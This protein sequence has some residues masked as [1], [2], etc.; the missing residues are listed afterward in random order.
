M[1]PMMLTT[2]AKE[3]VRTQQHP[4]GS[5]QWYQEGQEDQVCV[6]QG[7]GPQVLEKSK[8]CQEVQWQEA[9]S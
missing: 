4:Q 1:T 3:H 7:Y 5:R 2:T 9:S 6:N 8:V